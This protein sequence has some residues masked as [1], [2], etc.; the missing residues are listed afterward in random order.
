MDYQKAREWYERSAV[1]NIAAAV[2]NLAVMY[3]NG[4][5]VEK[6]DETAIYLY[7]Q[8]ANMGSVICAK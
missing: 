8:A 3:E 2:N 1:N 5:G 4:E 6:D 7:R